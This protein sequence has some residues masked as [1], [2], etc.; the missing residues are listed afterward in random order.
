MINRKI[1]LVLDE[2]KQAARAI[3][4]ENF[5][6]IVYFIQFFFQYIFDFFFQK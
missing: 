5:A 4:T 2:K 1:E 6:E 3:R